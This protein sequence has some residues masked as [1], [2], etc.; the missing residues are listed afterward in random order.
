MILF[1]V[2]NSWVKDSNFH[3]TGGKLSLSVISQLTH[4]ND[5]VE[6]QLQNLNLSPANSKNHACFTTHRL[7]MMYSSLGLIHFIFIYSTQVPS[8][9]EAAKQKDTFLCSP[10]L[11]NIQEEPGAMRWMLSKQPQG[12]SWMA[13]DARLLQD[14]RLHQSPAPT[15]AQGHCWNCWHSRC[16]RKSW[17]TLK[18]LHWSFYPAAGLDTQKEVLSPAAPLSKSF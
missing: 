17:A 14:F 16:F 9:A 13:L 3:F 7:E 18:F 12:W 11:N 8:D 6:G 5:G 4:G 1:D 10:L 2:H 15:P